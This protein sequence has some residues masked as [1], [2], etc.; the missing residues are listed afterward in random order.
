VAITVTAPPVESPLWPQ[1]DIRDPLGVW[2]F[3][4]GVTGD[5]S[6][7]P[8]SVGI[9]VP[10]DK[11]SAYVYTMYSAQIAQL[12]GVITGSFLKLRLLTNWPNVDPQAGVQA[13]ASLILGILGGATDLN[14]PIAGPSSNSANPGGQSLIQPNDRFLLLF[15]PRQPASLGPM[16]IAN[17]ELQVNTNLATYSFEAY[18]YFWDRSVLQA[19][20]G[21]RHPGA[22]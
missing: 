9:E 5:A 19:P 6:G 7:N 8:I 1:G 11:R 20:G 16:E 14:A 15:D 2:G 4:L 3:R 18:G 21:L 17:L 13:Y 12:T 22:N 10:A